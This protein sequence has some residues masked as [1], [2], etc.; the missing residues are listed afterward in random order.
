MP[1][2]KVKGFK[3]KG[4]KVKGFKVKG[5]ECVSGGSMPYYRNSEGKLM[6]LFQK[7][8]NHKW[9]NIFQYEDWGGKSSKEDSCIEDCIARETDEETNKVLD[10]GEILKYLK[11]K[12]KVLMVNRGCKYAIAFIPL[13]SQIDTEAFGTYEITPDNYRINRIA[14]WVPADDIWNMDKKICHPRIR[15]LLKKILIYKSI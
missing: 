3:V 5:F 14:E 8:F 13:P 10:R 9:P 6:F 4:F 11:G 2:F 1:K 12:N 7:K 15:N